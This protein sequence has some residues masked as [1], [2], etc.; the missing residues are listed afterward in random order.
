MADVLASGSGGSRAA[1]IVAGSGF[2]TSGLAQAA[3]GLLAK[4]VGIMLR[5]C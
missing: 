4:D 5:R 2:D 1:G 3:A